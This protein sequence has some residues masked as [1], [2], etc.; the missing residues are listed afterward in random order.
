MGFVS[1]LED[2][3]KRIEL[4]KGETSRGFTP[5]ELAVSAQRKRLEKEAELLQDV[6]LTLLQKAH[7][8][9]E[10]ILTPASDKIALSVS[11][12]AI[13]KENNRLRRERLQLKKTLGI[14]SC[15][16]QKMQDQIAKMTARCQSLVRLRD[17]LGNSA[18]TTAVEHGVFIRELRQFVDEEISK[19]ID[20]HPHMKALTDSLS[21]RNSRIKDLESK[22]ITSEK[23]IKALRA[24]LAVT[25]S[26]HR[27]SGVQSGST[28][29]K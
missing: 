12:E 29:P 26:G 5:S 18:K 16:T 22:I 11:S 21:V 15:E 1:V 8:L 7:E 25:L 2:I 4:L 17:K 19:L 10:S 13:R 28:K 23:K 3:E 27:T 20:K 24:Q 14:L 6:A 9:R